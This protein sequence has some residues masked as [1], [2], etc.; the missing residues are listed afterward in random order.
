MDISYLH[1]RAVVGVLIGEAADQVAKD[2]A[3]V[4]ELEGNGYIIC[5]DGE[6]EPP[7]VEGLAFTSSNVT[8]DDT[9]LYFGTDDNPTGTLVVLRDYGVMDNVYSGGAVV[10]PN[11]VKVQAIAASVAPSDTGAVVDG[12]SEEFVAA[13]AAREAQRDEDDGA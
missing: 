2:A 5:F 3:W 9:A 12:P 8:A 1:G 13:E 7:A 4:I 11:E 10:R 6:Y